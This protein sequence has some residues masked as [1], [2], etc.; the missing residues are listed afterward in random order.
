M[1][2]KHRGG[3][4]KGSLREAWGGFRRGADTGIGEEVPVQKTSAKNLLRIT[5][6][7][8]RSKRTGQLSLDSY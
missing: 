3:R 4:D 7:S 1:D 2:K 8:L 5:H 6:F